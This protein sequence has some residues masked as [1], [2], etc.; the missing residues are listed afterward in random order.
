MVSLHQLLKT[1]VQQGASDLHL[2][3]GSPPVLRVQGRMV[4]VKSPELTPETCQKL[5]YS[6]LTDYQKGLFEE[7]REL[8]FS[9]GVKKMARFRANIF[10]QKGNVS[11]VF[12]QVPLVIPAFQDLGLPRTVGSLID[13]SN[14]LVL[15]TGPTGSGKTTTIASLMDKI[16]EEKSGHIMT[17]EDPIEYLYKHKKCIVNQREIGSDSL[18]FHE[19]LRVLLR[20]DPDYVMI[21]EMRDLETIEAALRISETGHLV[22]GTLHTNSAV[23]TINRLVNVFPGEQQDRIRTLLSFVL[24]GV[25]TQK[26][27]PTASGQLTAVSEVLVVNSS[28]AN[29]IRENKLHQ[30]YGMMQVGQEKSG[31]MTMNQSI[32]KKVLRRQIDL[33]TAFAF[34][35]DPEELDGILKKAGL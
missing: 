19:A 8:D 12:R 24:K 23:Q 5:C 32:M 1:A 15:I 14:G 13:Y 6:I 7:N 18:G 3:A 33:K 21:G 29:L 22:F 26:L 11:G 25:V 16:N 10:F 4:R 34:S 31:M 2:V 35:S 27:I 28:I 30:I 17:L 9:F 20:Q